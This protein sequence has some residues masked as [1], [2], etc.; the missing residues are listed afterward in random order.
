MVT[1]LYHLQGMG[2]GPLEDCTQA[3]C[4]T[5]QETYLKLHRVT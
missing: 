4:L 1:P 2:P 3:T 5:Q